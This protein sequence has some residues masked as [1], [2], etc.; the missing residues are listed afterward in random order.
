MS[1]RDEGTILSFSGNAADKPMR[2]ELGR[3][4]PEERDEI[5]TLFERKSG[6]VEL[7]RALA[8]MTRQDLEASGLYEKLAQ[9]IG[10]ATIQF[11]GWFDRTSRKYGWENLPGH[12][13]EVDFDACTVYLR[14]G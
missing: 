10:R 7:A 9:D 12:R 1:D 3:I 2:K 13:W 6:L 14:R 11:Q 5:R 8:G 4:T